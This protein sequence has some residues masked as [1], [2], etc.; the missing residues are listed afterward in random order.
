MHLNIGIEANIF[1]DRLTQEITTGGLTVVDAIE[2]LLGENLEDSV[3]ISFGNHII[4]TPRS[5]VHPSYYINRFEN[6]ACLPCS[7]LVGPRSCVVSIRIVSKQDCRIQFQKFIKSFPIEN[8]DLI[9]SNIFLYPQ[10]KQ[11]SFIEICDSLTKQN[12]ELYSAVLISTTGTVNVCSL[13]VKVY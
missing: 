4:K 13:S 7:R 1:A 12:G 9:C 3:L 6:L 11:I 5:I 8:A 10:R 2:K